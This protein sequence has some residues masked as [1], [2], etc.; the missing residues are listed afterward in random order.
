MK[1]AD[2]SLGEL[3]ESAFAAS[4]DAFEDELEI[5]EWPRVKQPRRLD[6]DRAACRTQQSHRRFLIQMAADLSPDRIRDP[7]RRAGSFGRDRLSGRV[8]DWD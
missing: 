4:A 2:D 1:R 6:I 7:V 8:D 5:F 3:R